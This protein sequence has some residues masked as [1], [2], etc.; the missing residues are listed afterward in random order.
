MLTSWLPAL[1]LAIGSRRHVPDQAG[2]LELTLRGC[3]SD[4]VVTTGSTARGP[5]DHLHG[6]LDALGATLIVDGVQVRPGHPQLLA[7][8][9]DGRPLVGLPGNPLA[10]VSGLLTLLEPLAAAL[11]GAR[12]GQLR[13][14]PGR[15]PPGWCRSVPGGRCCSPGPRCC[16]DW[17]R[18]R[19]SPSCR[20]AAPGRGTSSS[21]C[22]CP[23]PSRRD[24]ANPC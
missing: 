1:G 24:H 21:S 10:A 13:C 14:L 17:R 11:A 6:L 7:L 4:V 3:L 23:D 18:P 12:G 5:V 22:P 16:A 20:P 19:T 8:L 15:R 2:A 9:P